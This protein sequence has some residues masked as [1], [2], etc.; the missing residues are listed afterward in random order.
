MLSI[1]C[2]DPHNSKLALKCFYYDCK[3]DL[4]NF[5]I[6]KP[7]QKDDNPLSRPQI[8]VIVISYNFDDNLK[9][10]LYF[11]LLYLVLSNETS[12]QIRNN[13]FCTLYLYIYISYLCIIYYSHQRYNFTV[14]RRY[15]FN[16]NFRIFEYGTRDCRNTRIFAAMYY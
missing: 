12:K 3:Y 13:I 5:G 9:I 7:G 10:S 8:G 14:S 15:K 4:A 2:Y 16:A 1:I 6:Y 11:V